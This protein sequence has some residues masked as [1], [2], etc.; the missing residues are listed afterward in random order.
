MSINT[1]YV[2]DLILNIVKIINSQKIKI[3]YKNNNFI[4]SLKEYDNMDFYNNNYELRLYDKKSSRPK[5][6]CSS[7]SPELKSDDLISKEICFVAKKP[8]NIKLIQK[9]RNES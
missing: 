3:S 6:D 9:S 2:S 4:L 1:R 5:Y 7:F 8:S